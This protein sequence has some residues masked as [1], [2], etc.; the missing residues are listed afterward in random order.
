MGAVIRYRGGGGGAYYEYHWI[1]GAVKKL[2][3]FNKRG[4]YHSLGIK[5]LFIFS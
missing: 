5:L 3:F 4:Y 2:F 1:W